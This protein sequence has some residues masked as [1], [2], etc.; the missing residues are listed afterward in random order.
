MTPEEAMEELRHGARN[1]QFDAELVESFITLLEREGATF[2]REA[3]FET[4]LEFERRVRQAAEPSL[5]DRAA[6]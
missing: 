5:A 3:D 6:R 4:E 2:A 1:G